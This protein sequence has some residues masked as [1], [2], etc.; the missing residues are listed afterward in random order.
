MKKSDFWGMIWINIKTRVPPAADNY[1]LMWNPERK[2]AFVLKSYE[3]HQAAQGILRGDF[4]SWD[5]YFT[6]WCPIEPPEKKLKG[7]RTK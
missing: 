6:E 1:I 4:V 7:G 3:A 2:E 5:R